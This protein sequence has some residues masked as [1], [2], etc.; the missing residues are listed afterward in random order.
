MELK[1]DELIKKLQDKKELPHLLAVFGD[2]DYYKGRITAALPEYVYGDTP[3]ED[4]EITV[5]EKDTNFSALDSAINSYPFFSGHSLILIKDEK[6]FGKADGEEANNS[7]QL[8][9][10]QELVADIPEYCT[11]VILANKL[12]KRTKFFK[13][14]RAEGLVCECKRIKTYQ[15]SGW[16]EMQAAQAGGRFDREA[17]ETIMEYLVPVEEAPLALLEQEINKLAVYAGARTTWTKAD[18]EAIFA[19]LPEAGAFAINNALAERNLPL[20]LDLLAGERKRGTYLLPLCGMIMYQLRR[21]LRFLEMNRCRYDQK[22]ISSELKIPPFMYKRFA[23][24]Y[25]RF[26][27]AELKQALLDVGQVN[28]DLRKGG[29]GFASLEEAF[30]K[31]LG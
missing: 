2:E 24:Q 13:M 29:R 19:A 11:V 30:I 15:L 28:M 14:L 20:V 16:L 31:L 21:M 18:V 8:E 27:E 1:P 26:R 22:T 5:F 9:K 7:K 17:V 12:D 4:R 23:V 3:V 25:T 10:L 6:I